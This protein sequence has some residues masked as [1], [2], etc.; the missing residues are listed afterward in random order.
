M[1]WTVGQEVA[2]SGLG[3]SRTGVALSKVKRVLKRFVELED[4]SQWAH[5]GSSYPYA[6]YSC[7]HIEPLVTDEHRAK[8]RRQRMIRYIEKRRRDLQP[9]WCEIS[10]DTLAAV[11]KLLSKDPEQP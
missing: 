5:N 4:G 2:V 11:A 6:P 7:G 1:E 3:L 8:V 9:L 10:T